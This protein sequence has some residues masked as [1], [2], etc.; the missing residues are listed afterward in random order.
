[1][2]DMLVKAP[3]CQE[4]ALADYLGGMAAVSGFSEALENS[5]IFPARY[6]AALSDASFYCELRKFVLYDSI[7]DKWML[8]VVNNLARVILAMSSV[9]VTLW[10]VLTGSRFIFGTNKEP[11]FDLLFRGAKIVLVLS[12]VSG[13]LGTTDT[14]IHTVLG[15]QNAITTIVTGSDM[16]VDRLIDMNIA[17]SQVMNMV[18]EDITNATSEQET[19]TGS[20]SIFAG[21]LGQSG[22]AILTSVLVLLSQIAI[23]FAL[24]LAPL[25][26]FFLL[27]KETS[28]LFWSW[29]K[30]LL[31]SF[32]SLCFLAIVST[33]AMSASL[34]YGMT[35]MVSYVLNSIADAGGAL[36]ATAFQIGLG[37]IAELLISL[38]TGGG[39]R[40]DM[41][42]AA[43]RMAMMGGLFA[44]L[45]VAVPPMIMQMFNASIGYASNVMGSMGI[46][47]PMGQP[48][49]GGAGQSVSSPALI[50]A[51]ASGSTAGLSGPAGGMANSNNQMLINRA[52]SQ[53]MVSGPEGAAGQVGGARAMGGGVMG[54]AAPGADNARVAQIQNKQSGDEFRARSGGG[55]TSQDGSSMKF[56]SNGT[57]VE[58]AVLK[59]H[60]HLGTGGA[61]QPAES[62]ASGSQNS[63][64]GGAVIRDSSPGVS[65]G[66]AGAWGGGHSGPATKA[67]TPSASA[68]ASSAP[69]GSSAPSSA[70]ETPVHAAPPRGQQGAASNNGAVHAR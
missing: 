54:L 27:F 64:G 8:F 18:V 39:N 35:I 24:M 20:F 34:S 14:I 23:V 30:F 42:G 43:M 47:R 32:L 63:V 5:G 46:I 12:L 31:G 3:S 29:S 67:G 56:Y 41:S 68:P 40:V 62:Q 28:S 53:A 33:I 38:L 51:G 52:N 17:I 60:K 2:F 65:M 48:L 10:L 69:S 44:T 6:L 58:D 21:L 9:F 37:A 70:S 61:L 36:N 4:L 59:E 49:G 11:F 19:K 15:L 1:M 57:N 26:V 16:G 55:G 7:L 13:M 22:P 25:F 50:G 45:I 66:G